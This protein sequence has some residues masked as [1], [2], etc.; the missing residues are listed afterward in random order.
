MKKWDFVKLVAENTGMSQQDVN[1]VI[2]EAGR[3][4]VEQCRDKGEDISIPT[5]GSFKQKVNAAR[6][7]RNP[8]TGEQIDIKGS[9][10][11]VFRPMPSVKVVEEPKKG[12]K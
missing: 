5:I 2:D 10:T 8:L 3:V 4:I 11:I 7:G 12:K 1:K 9:R 6:K